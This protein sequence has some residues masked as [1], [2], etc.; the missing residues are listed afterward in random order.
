MIST[1]NSHLLIKSQLEQN[2]K[3]IN[4]LIN[5]NQKKLI[6]GQQMAP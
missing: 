1:N 6:W 4:T 2:F 3:H 5:I